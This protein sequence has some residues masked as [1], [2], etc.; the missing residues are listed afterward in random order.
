MVAPIHISLF[1]VVGFLASCAMPTS[2]ISGQ[3]RVTEQEIKEITPVIHKQTH[4][5]SET[6][7]GF[8]RQANGTIDVWTTSDTIYIVR[9]VDHTWKI[10]GTTAV[11]R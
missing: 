5:T 9:R 1:V 7:T 4:H 6:I 3:P 2:D 11:E 8:Y 10:V